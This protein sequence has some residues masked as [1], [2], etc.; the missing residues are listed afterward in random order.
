MNA[1]IHQQL[2]NRKSRIERR[3]DKKKIGNTDRPVAGGQMKLGDGRAI[4]LA[5]DSPTLLTA[6][7]KVVLDDSYRVAVADREGLSDPGDTEYFIRTLEDRPPEVHIIKPASDR[8]VTRLEE[9]EVEAQ[10][11]DDY[12][13]DKLELVYSVRGTKEKVVPLGTIELA[14]AW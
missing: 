1:K 8:S 13:I 6:T 11:D 5:A 9:V 4:G 12:G 7:L 14:R 10:A 2:G 3:L